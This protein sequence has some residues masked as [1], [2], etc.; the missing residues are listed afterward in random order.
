MTIIGAIVVMLPLFIFAASQINKVPMERIR[1]TLDTPNN[2]KLGFWG[3]IFQQ[4]KTAVVPKPGDKFNVTAV[5][6]SSSVDQTDLSPCITAAGTVVRKGVVATNFL[7]LGTRLKIGEDIFV[8]EDRMNTKY[9]GK[10][11]IDVWHPSRREALAFGKKNLEIEVLPQVEEEEP[12]LETSPTPTPKPNL[13]NKTMSQI[14][15]M[16]NFFSRFTPAKSLTPADANCE[17]ILKA[18]SIQ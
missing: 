16:G 6:Y 15:S 11:I 18:K 8:V 12:I 9:N 10:K 2:T 17:K 7:P 13:W 3:K 14:S 1:V 4:L 5:A